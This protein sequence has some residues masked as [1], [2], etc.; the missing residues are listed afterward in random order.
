MTITRNRATLLPVLAWRG[1]G[2][3]LRRSENPLRQNKP[4]PLDP[5]TSRRPD[6]VRCYSGRRND[7]GS[8]TIY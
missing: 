6:R 8:G 1:A 7:G 2:A 5:L 4:N 3:N